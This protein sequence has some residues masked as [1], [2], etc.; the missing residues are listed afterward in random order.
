MIEE[1]DTS[2]GLADAAPIPILYKDEFLLLV[3]KP[4][5]MLTTPGRGADKQDCLYHRLLQDYPNARV[6]H[7]LDMATSGIVI[8]ALSHPAQAAMGKLFEQ[9][10][11]QKTYIADVSGQLQQ[12][13]GEIDLPLICDWE[14]RPLQKVCYESGKSAQTR[15]SLVAYDPLKDVSRLKLEPLTGRS[16]QLRVHMLALGHPILGDVFYHPEFTQMDSARLL[17]HA[18][19]VAFVHP[20]TQQPLDISSP[21]PF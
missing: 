16:H 4:A 6:V 5:N 10:L 15:Y 19:Q 12:A 17:L 21:V 13:K 1:H 9:R 8:F 3:D 18:H 14:N 11:I 2:A 20:I 7:R